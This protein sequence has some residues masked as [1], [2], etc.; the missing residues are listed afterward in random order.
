MFTVIGK[1]VLWISIRDPDSIGPLDPD[2]HTQSGPGSGSKR[3]KMAQK[4]IKP[5]EI[6]SFYVLD[7]FF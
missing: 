6:S 7:V 3:A 1:P 5:F 4:N 2:P